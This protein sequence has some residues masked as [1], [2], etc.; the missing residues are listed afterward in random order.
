[1]IHRGI[2]THVSLVVSLLVVSLEHVFSILINAPYQVPL[3][4]QMDPSTDYMIPIFV[5]T[6]NRGPWTS[7][8]TDTQPIKRN[9]RF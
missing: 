9:V 2:L 7:V 5:V 8:K 4:G 6:G 3:W 1:M